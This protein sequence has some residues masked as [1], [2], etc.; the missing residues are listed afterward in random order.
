[1]LKYVKI[2]LRTVMSGKRVLMVINRKR[3]GALRIHPNGIAQ[4]TNGHCHYALPTDQ[5]VNERVIQVN[6]H[7]VLFQL[8]QD[9][10]CNFEELQRVVWEYEGALK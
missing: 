6:K 9:T 3:T 7:D 10:G 8:A 4:V 1:M 5:R 2:Y